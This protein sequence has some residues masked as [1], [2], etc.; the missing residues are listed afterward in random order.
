MR[1]RTL[2]QEQAQRDVIGTYTY[3]NGGNATVT[4]MTS[5]NYYKYYKCCKDEVHPDYPKSGGPLSIVSY[6]TMYNDARIK[7]GYIGYANYSGTV[8]DAVR[9]VESYQSI[10]IPTDG[11]AACSA[12]GPEAWSKFRPKLST[13]GLGQAFAEAKDIP[14]LFKVRLKEFKDLGGNYL[15]YQFGW[16]PF[17]KD[18]KDWLNSIRNMDQQLAKLKRNNGRWIKSHGELFCNENHTS[19]LYLYVTPSNGLTIQDKSREVKTFDRCWFSGSFRYYIPGI[20]DGSWGKLKLTSKLWGLELTPSLAYELMPWS[21]LIDWFGNVGDVISNYTS[22]NYD[23]MA[24]RYAYVMRH[25]KTTE[26]CKATV[27]AAY[28]EWGKPTD[29]SIHRLSTVVDAE[30]KCRAAASPFGFNLEMA[31]FSNYQLSILTA[32][33]ISRYT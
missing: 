30:T 24:S 15:N 12:K 20:T 25:T 8:V 23:N 9:R 1:T 28:S 26:I 18:L 32:L 6:R 5:E 27:K 14:D 29:Y 22:I 11:L 2:G 13:V 3:Y 21:W 7:S 17:V 19:D 16:V 33:G 4:E 10:P 31:D